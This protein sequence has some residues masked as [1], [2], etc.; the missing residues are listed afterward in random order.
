[1]KKEG[2]EG[3]AQFGI[4]NFERRRSPRF[5]MDLPVEFSPVDSQTRFLGTGRTGNASEG[6]LMLYL[7]GKLK[8]GQSLRIR[9]YFT[10]DPG[11]DSIEVAAEVVW[12]E[13]PFAAEGDHR[14]GVRF[15]DISPED[16]NRLKNFLDNLAQIRP[17][18]RIAR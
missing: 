4:A 14:Y 12:V 3:R 10:S 7:P 1:M 8:I 15:L 11:L 9:L 5:S 16:L 18:L 13:F 17:P 2:Q 6:G